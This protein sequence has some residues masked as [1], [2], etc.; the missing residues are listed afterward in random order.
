LDAAFGLFPDPLS[1]AVAGGLAPPH[2]EAPP[3]RAKSVRAHE[4]ACE[5][6]P[7]PRLL[8]AVM[9]ARRRAGRL[10]VLAAATREGLERQAMERTVAVVGATGVVGREMLKTLEA[11]SF[12]AAR[13]IALASP[14]SAGAR[15]PFRGGEIE[16]KVATPE[17]FEGVSIALFSA[18]ASVAR[19]LG[20]AAAAR[21]AVVIDNSSA[22][23]MDP[24]VPLV[25]PEVNMDAAVNRPRGI[26]ANP[27]CSTIQMV[28]ALKPL[29][30][31]AR[32]RHIV[33]STYQAASGKGHA[34]VEELIEQTREAAAGGFPKASVFPGVLAGNLL[35]DW[36]PGANDYSEEE[37]KMVNETRKILGDSSIGVS[38]TT[39]RVPVV[40]GHSEA[41]HV[42]FHR[43]MQAEE[44]K[45]LLAGA[46]GVTLIDGPYAPGKHP[47]PLAIAG[48]DDVFVGRVRDD[49]AVP[50]AINLWVV[51]DNLRKGAAL[52]AV[53]IAERLLG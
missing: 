13:V 14:R 21:G 18:G 7:P 38:P 52:N 24:E 33:V 25:V 48:T 5:D 23:R 36:K 35:M 26:I 22:W 15:V 2:A 9:V 20:P 50:G 8:I 49:L 17:A 19:E 43:P 4:I 45:R 37:L 16:V 3:A 47:Q 1:G 29:H 6:R 46:P 32:I 10:S 44:A 40:T 34:A 27:N 51:A 11:R 39:V 31:A 53:Q 12:P 30:D 28:V 41:V 42:Q